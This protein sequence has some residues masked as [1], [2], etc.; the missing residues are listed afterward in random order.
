[1]TVK[2][3]ILLWLVTAMLPFSGISAPTAADLVNKAAVALKSAPAVS[4]TFTY[5]IGSRSGSGSLQLS[6]RKF[7]FSSPQSSCWYDG[8]NLWTYS[9]A[10]KETTLVTPTAEELA[11]S[12]P[13]S[14]ISSGAAGFTCTLDNRSSTASQKIIEMIPRRKKQGIKK[15][16]LTLSYPSLEPRRIV[17][18]GSDGTVSSISIRKLQKLKALPAANFTYPVNKFKGIKIIDLR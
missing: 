6:G 15:V 17:I 11:E 2:L 12:N 4:A 14:Y 13:L 16:T 18:A 1:M 3:K 5:K 8:K 10:S 9:A 7:A